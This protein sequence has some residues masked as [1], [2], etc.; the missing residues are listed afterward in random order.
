M[1]SKVVGLLR[2]A[3]TGDVV[4]RCPKTDPGGEEG[5]GYEARVG[6]LSSTDSEV[7]P[8]RKQIHPSVGHCKI[9]GHVGILVEEAFDDW[10]Q[11]RLAQIDGSCDAQ[12][13]GRFGD[14]LQ[15]A[16]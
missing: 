5:A 7:D 13:A 12:P 16:Y 6:K 14:G 2:H 9:N 8:F 1:T 10:R 15:S 3:T 4:T 11:N